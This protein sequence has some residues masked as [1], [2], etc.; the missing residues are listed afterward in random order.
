MLRYFVNA[1]NQSKY[2][3]AKHLNIYYPFQVIKYDSLIDTHNIVVHLENTKKVLPLKIPR[4]FSQ[5]QQLPTMLLVISL[6]LFL[7][8][9]SP[10]RKSAEPSEMGLLV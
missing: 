1:I 6:I 10:P 7:L 2:I 9:F 5:Y 8:L 3:N 4:F